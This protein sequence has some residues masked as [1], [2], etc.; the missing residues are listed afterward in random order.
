MD[1]PHRLHSVLAFARSAWYAC[2]MFSTC[3]LT[4]TNAS[5]QGPSQGSGSSA[6]LALDK[7]RSIIAAGD[8][9]GAVDFFKVATG[10]FPR[11]A[12]LWHE[13][14]MLLSA[15]NKPYWRKS[16]MPAGIPQRF[17]IADSAL[18]RATWLAPD[19]ARY[20]LDYGE[21]LFNTNQWNFANAM[22]MQSL[23]VERAENNAD[24]LTVAQSRDA[25]GL[26]YWRRYETV[27]HRGYFILELEPGGLTYGARALKNRDFIDNGTRLYKPP[28]GEALY[29]EAASNFKKA[30][31][32]NV[33]DEMAFRHEA[34]L[35]AERSRWEELAIL[36]N[37]RI[38]TRPAQIW[39]W[40][41]LGLAEHRRGRLALG[42][43]ALDSGFAKLPKEDRERLSSLTR[44]L[45]PK[46]QKFFDTLD[47]S[48]RQ[49]LEQS[50][51]SLANPSLL[52]EGNAVWDEFRARLAFAELMWT[53]EQMQVRGADS[54]RGEVLVRWGPPDNVMTTGPNGTGMLGLIWLYRKSGFLVQFDMAPTYGTAR[55]GPDARS[56]LEA[57]ILVHAAGFDNLALFRNGIDSIPVQVA[58]FRQSVDSIDL[59]VFAGIRTAK[60]RAGSPADTTLLKTG[61][62]AIDGAGAVA[63][64]KTDVLRTAEQDT[65]TVT[66]RSWRTRVPT[67]TSY[68][69]VEALDEDVSRAARAIRDV[70]GFSTAGFGISDLLIGNGIVAPPNADAARWSDY[71]ISPIAGNVL[72]EKRPVDLLWEMYSPTAQNGTVRYRVSITMQREEPTGLVGVAVK[73]VGGIRN[74]ILRSGSTNRIAVEYERSIAATNIRTESLRLDLGNA[75]AG[76]YLMTLEITDL[77]SGGSA[78]THRDIVLV[79]R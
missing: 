52:A 62:F 71:K 55:L 77:N 57:E 38:K 74:A 46:H 59:A 32:L 41:A 37:G 67:R 72:R 17:T 68:V 29:V 78:I 43:S 51:V 39:P 13:Y 40:L 22:R 2:A 11:S 19:S 4:A 44:L 36:A 63:S 70:T 56:I 15:W 69:R 58:R 27:A 33:D 25:L 28:L 26:F 65:A 12:A 3:L 48:A 54:D 24:T 66:S 76:R 23:A 30:R 6:A 61:V 14:G 1:W 47:A 73:A 75:R 50:Y 16:S 20:A 18:A 34:M 64:R 60:L 49:R 5:A 10:D 21:H 42:S 53:N 8:T 79:E 7:A 9:S 45:P 35:L 31:E